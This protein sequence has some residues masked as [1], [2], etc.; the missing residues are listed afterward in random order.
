V[1]DADVTEL[2]AARELFPC[3]FGSGLREEGVTEFLDGL[4]RWSPAARCGTD[5]AAGVFKITRGEK[6][7]RL[8]HV[9]LTGGTLTVRDALR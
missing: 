4:A 1:E 7:E 3:F 5:F 9:K 2:I 8:T 6:G